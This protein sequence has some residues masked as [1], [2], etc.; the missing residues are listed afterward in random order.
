MLGRR[1]ALRD[2]LIMFFKCCFAAFRLQNIHWIDMIV[3]SFPL[4]P[5]SICKVF[6][7]S[8]KTNQN[9]EAHKN[10]HYGCAKKNDHL[11]TVKLLQQPLG[12]IAC[13]AV[14][15]A[16]PGLHTTRRCHAVF[17]MKSAKHLQQSKTNSVRSAYLILMDA[18]QY[19]CLL[20]ARY[21]ELCQPP[22][23]SIPPA[24]FNQRHFRSW[25]TAQAPT[26]KHNI[27]PVPD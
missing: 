16:F 4:F 5:R 8:C 1:I 23:R 19:T 12:T 27:C 25:Q 17:S 13:V 20:S 14:A 6:L 3:T 18:R 7:C 26:M 10:P 24:S 22:A 9:K 11:Q 21:R 2:S 15:K